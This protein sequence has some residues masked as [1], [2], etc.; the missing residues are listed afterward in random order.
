MEFKPIYYS[1]RLKIVNPQGNVGIV[2]LWTPLEDMT[3]KEKGKEI[4]LKGILPEIREKIPE[5]LN[6]NSPVAV[7]ANLYGNGLPQMLA[8]LLY[9]PQIDRIVITGADTEK[10]GRALLNFFKKGVERINESGIEFNRII[11][12][13]EYPLDLQLDPSRFG[14]LEIERFRKNDLEEILSFVQQPIIKTRSETDRTKIELVIPKFSDY[15]IEESLP[16]IIVDR[17][18]EGYMEVLYYLDRWGRNIDLDKYQENKKGK[19]RWLQNLD[20]T[21]RNPSFEDEDLLKKFNFDSQGL[22][23]YQEKILSGEMPEDQPYG[24]GH[25]FRTYFGIDQLKEIAER[26]KRNPF[27]RH[28]FMSTWDQSKDVLQEKDSSSPCLTDIYFV[29]LDG[30]LRMTASFRTH[31]AISGWLK[32]FYGLMAIQDFVSSYSGIS[33]GPITV[34]SRWLGIDPDNTKTITALNI[35]KQIRKVPLNVNDPRGYTLIEADAQAKELV[36]Q[37]YTRDGKLLDEYRSKDFTGMKDQLR[38][39]RAFTDFDHGM[40]IGYT[41]GEA[42]RKLNGEPQES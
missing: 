42:E 8:N 9:N 12:S 29:N 31:N 36:L 32:N 18:L 33:R 27:D 7:V 4:P 3:L 15:P 30:Q 2:T 25:R 40:W 26:L 21:V 28:A 1:D 38:H 35:S 22:K 19:R 5:L 10:S 16:P 39:T 24:Y 13:T 20:A 6:E 11:D 34:R 41:L 14:Q 37:H 23:E 17:P